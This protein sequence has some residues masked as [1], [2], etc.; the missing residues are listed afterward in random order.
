MR[1]ILLTTALA[2][3]A[4]GAWADDLAL[5]LGSDRYGNLDRVQRGA[6]VATATSGISA[7]GFTVT[8]L[9]DAPSAD[10]TAALGSFIEA[11]P[12]A[13]RAIIVLSGRFATDGL[14]SWY[15][16]QDAE[17]PDLVSI[18]RIG[19][20]LESLMQL[21]AT[22]PGKALLVLAPA[23]GDDRTYGDYLS[24]GIGDLDIAQGV[25]VLQGDPRYVTDFL[26]DYLSIPEG[27]LP[28]LVAD[29][30]RLVAMGFMPE[31]FAFMPNAPQI[32]PAPPPTTTPTVDTAA[33]DDDLWRRSVAQDNVD[34]Y[35]AYLR[36]FPNGRHTSEA[37]AA[38]AAIL[39]EPFRAD[40]LAEEGLALTRD[41]R[42]DIQGDLTLLGFDTRGVDGILGAGSRRA[43]TNWQQENGFA[44]TG[45][46]TR[47]QINRIDAQAARRA[48]ERE[49][50]AE[51]QRQE[52]ERLDRAY[53]DETGARGDETGLRTYLGR[54][55][56]GV[57]AATAREELSRIEDQNRQ[58]SAAR[59]REAWNAARDRDNVGAY[60]EYLR[61]FPQGAFV[62]DANA[63]IAAL[64]GGPN[65][66][67]GVTPAEPERPAE[68][69]E[70][71]ERAERALG[72]NALTGRLVESRL[73]AL[74][75]DPGAV[76]GTFDAAT[77][78]ALRAYQESAG[79]PA[80]GY[81]NENTL[82]TLVAGAL[83]GG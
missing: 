64:T 83:G 10:V 24:A 70:A 21:L 71:L 61:S 27:D 20:S 37:E 3:L 31:D 17:V 80:T 13:E 76:D 52:A 4:Q 9:R 19:V 77:R 23:G 16:P 59:D 50:E 51:R 79:V 66:G 32:A 40:R 22:K 53:W 44:Q 1:R 58:Q 38:I 7:L 5:V 78:R 62:A 57:F 43:I 46:V 63:R 41:Q 81:L 25:S 2:L 35:R 68:D 47:E 54:Y 12:E 73:A 65:G 48:A 55:P 26:N 34:A 42:R 60:R 49:A 33:Q 36:Q 15:L 29:Q 74:G 18:G 72:V 30:G 82:L 6:D 11:L 39:E 28:A 45:Y 14:R 69:T 75:F 67:P 8:A 56:E